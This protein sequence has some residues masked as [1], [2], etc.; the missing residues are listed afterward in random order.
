MKQIQEDEDQANSQASCP[1]S[2][3]KKTK[4]AVMERRTHKSLP[5][6]LKSWKHFDYPYIRRNLKKIFR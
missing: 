2:L 3:P 1:K 6:D 5:K 4:I